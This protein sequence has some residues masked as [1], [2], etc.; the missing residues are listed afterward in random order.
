[1]KKITI[2]TCA[3]A[4][5][6]VACGDDDDDGTTTI[7]DLG[8]T[9]GGETDAE[10]DSGGGEATSFTLTVENTAMGFAFPASGVFSMPD[11]TTEAGPIGPDGSYTLTFKAAPRYPGQMNTTRLSFATM[12]VPSNDLFI[13][14]PATGLPLFDDAGMPITGDRSSEVMVWDAGSEA[15]QPLG[16]PAET[17]EN[18]K[19]HQAAD[20]EDV[21]PADDNVNV[22]LA[23]ETYPT[24]PDASRVIE[25]MVAAEEVDREWVFT[26]T[27]TNVSMPGTINPL[28]PFMGAVPM[29]PGVWV[30][31][32]QADADPGPLFT[33]GEADRG[34]GL[35]DIAEDGF[36]MRLATSLMA[37]TGLTVVSSP[38]AY[39]VH[40]SGTEPL[41]MDGSTDLGQGL[42]AIAEDG[43]P[44]ALATSL[45]GNE[46]VAAS[47]AIGEMPIGPGGTFTV[48]FEASPDDRLSLATMVVPSNDLIF[49]FGSR[50]IALF[51]ED[52]TPRSGEV[53]GDLRIWDVGTEVD[54]APGVGLDQVHLQPAPDTGA[55]DANTNVREYS[56]DAYPSASSS[57]SITLTP[58]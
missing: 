31:H 20:A 36:P 57:L 5:G 16:G 33:V 18:Q 47:G 52:G 53:G 50:G 23:S 1:M 4:L 55:A 32:N 24:I 2:L 14:S 49:S 43:M 29:S 15:D 13:A 54:Q 41:F 19:P 34:E 8:R 10:T 38:G 17:S 42:E 40:G 56:E 46:D 11:G 44:M 58:S 26:V 35:D 30:V 9:D 3:L 7:A 25:L 39:A 21:G 45:A 48:T 37:R 27:I 28:G 51:N 22:R 12:F 6:F